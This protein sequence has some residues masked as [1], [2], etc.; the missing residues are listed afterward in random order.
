MT[1]IDDQLTVGDLRD[2]LEEIPDDTPVNVG[3]CGAVGYAKR[4]NYNADGFIIQE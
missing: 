4:C 3:A 1:H 2:A